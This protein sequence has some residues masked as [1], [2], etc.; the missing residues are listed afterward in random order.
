[1]NFKYFEHILIE[2]ILV[3]L[4]VF[5]VYDVT[6]LREVNVAILDIIVGQ[7]NHLLLHRIQSKHFHGIY[8][9]LK[10]IAPF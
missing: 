2:N 3:L 5:L 1:M 7:V 4:S 8:Q 6:K 9:I 10:T